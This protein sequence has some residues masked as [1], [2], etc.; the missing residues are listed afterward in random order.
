[1]TAKDA[2]G[3]VSDFKTKLTNTELGFYQGDDK[4]AHINDNTLIISK[5]QI[6]T[7]LSVVGNAPTL[8]VGNFIFI[9]ES[10]G[11]FSISTDIS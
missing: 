2:N 1:M 11:S 4:V 7:E 3:N 5:A 8:K 9:Q 6:N 10:N